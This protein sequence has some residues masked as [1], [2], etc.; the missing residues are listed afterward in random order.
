MLHSVMTTFHSLVFV[1]LAENDGVT[2]RRIHTRLIFNMTFMWPAVYPYVLKVVISQKITK[3][4]FSF[5][6]IVYHAISAG[7]KSLR[8]SY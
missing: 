7:S 5:L 8:K 4:L 1:N 2:L 6:K 3:K